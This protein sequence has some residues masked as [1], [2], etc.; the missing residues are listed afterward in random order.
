MHYDLSPPPP[1]SIH[2]NIENTQGF[3]HLLYSIRCCSSHPKTRLQERFFREWKGG[4][5]RTKKEEGGIFS[6]SLSQERKLS[7]FHLSSPSS[8][9]PSPIFPPQKMSDV[10]GGRRFVP[11]WLPRP[12]AADTG[13]GEQKKERR[14]GMGGS[15]LVIC[16]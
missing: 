10:G 4:Q 16:R 12:T 7:H 14:V 13:G 8:L 9:S 3:P 6:S 1:P 15:E 5:R 2:K 11:N